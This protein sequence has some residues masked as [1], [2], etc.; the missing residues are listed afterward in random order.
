[1][2]NKAALSASEAVNLVYR[3]ARADDKGRRR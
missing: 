3:L 1:M 2:K